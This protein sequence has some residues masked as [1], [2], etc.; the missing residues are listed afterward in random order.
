MISSPLATQPL[1][2]FGP[3][4]ISTPV[5]T[6]WVVMA[7][8]WAG[9]ALVT[10]HLRLA[11][12][13]A[14][15]VFELLVGT[16]DEQIRGTMQA[17]PAQYRALIGTLFLLILACNWSSL[18]PG[19]EPPTAHI[20]TD[21]ALALIVF[22]ATI[23]YGVRARGLRRYLG[24]FAEPTWIMIPLNLVEQLTR[25]FSL[26]VRLF[27]NVM[28]GVFIVGIVLSLAGLLVPIPLMALDLLTGAVQAYIFSV[29]AMV[30]IGAALDESRP[31]QADK[32]RGMS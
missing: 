14:Q 32:E 11:P 9:A 6:T 12:S 24:T 2:H 7:V 31:A 5:V 16:I 19:V 18:L 1:F 3:V 25:T 13:K 21:V 15:T 20:E 29:L 8:L 27:G 22:C 17:E 23:F 4:P 30:F 10:R 28:S 26:I